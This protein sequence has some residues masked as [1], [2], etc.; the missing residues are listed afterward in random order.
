MAEAKIY[1]SG[2]RVFSP[3]QGSPDFVRG[4]IVITPNALYKWLKENPTLL[5]EYN[6]EKQIS[7]DLLDGNKGLYVAVNTY[8][9]DNQQ[10]PTQSSQPGKSAPY[11]QKNTFID[12][13]ASE[14]LPF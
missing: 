14:S 10:G 6:G 12:N 3:R 7:L 2:I 13:D 4:S 8:Q 1:P 11:Q 5:S 9:K